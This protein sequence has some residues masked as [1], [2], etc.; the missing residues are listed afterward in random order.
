MIANLGARA[1]WALS[2][3]GLAGAGLFASWQSG[4]LWPAAACDQTAVVW[5]YEVGQ[6]A[7]GST[8]VR[9]V[10]FD[11]VPAACEQTPVQVQFRSGDQVVDTRFTT[12]GEG[13]VLAAVPAD[14]AIWVPVG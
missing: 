9:G 11:D 12:L 14:G 13:E 6:A 10:R 8:Q 7:D 1:G 3:V 4:Q 2:L 5:T